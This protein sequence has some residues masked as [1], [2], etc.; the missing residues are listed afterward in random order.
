MLQATGQGLS[1]RG[2]IELDESFFSEIPDKLAAVNYFEF[3]VAEANWLDIRKLRVTL[4]SWAT[5]LDYVG[6]GD[7]S[8]T[9]GGVPTAL[10]IDGEV[11]LRNFRVE[12]IVFAPL[13]TGS[14][15][16]SLDSGVNLELSQPEALDPADKIELVLDRNFLPLELAIVRDEIAITATG[17]GEI[18]K[19]AT[20]NVPLDFLKT[21]AIN[22]EDITVPEN[23]AVQPIG[24]KLSGEFVFNLNTLATSGSNII[25]DSPSWASIKGERLTGEFQYADNYF[26]LQN[27]EFQ[28]RDSTYQL[29]GSLLQTADDFEVDGKASI[30]QGKIQDILIALQIFQLQDLGM[31]FGDREYGNAEDLYGEETSPILL[32]LV[33]AW[34]MPPSSNSYNY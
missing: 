15:Q 25:I 27:G 23:L 26:A 16:T 22:S 12:D 13:L 34:I 14:I 8:G 31:L 29:E 19:I 32:Y 21:V 30:S 1:A 28:Q 33:W 18:L 2:Y 7:F 9:I 24:G 6:R 5:N 20:N 10:N 4:P 3:D 17:E 11:N